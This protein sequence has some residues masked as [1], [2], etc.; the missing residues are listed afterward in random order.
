[1]VRSARAPSI[2][3]IADRGEEYLP[4]V[5]ARPVEDID[6]QPDDPSCGFAV[7]LRACMQIKQQGGGLANSSFVAHFTAFGCL[8]R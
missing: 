8:I 5:T 3:D 1:L 7:G 6:H 4:A 2:A